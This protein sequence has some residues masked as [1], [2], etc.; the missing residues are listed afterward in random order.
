MVLGNAGRR[1]DDVAAADE[2]GQLIVIRGNHEVDPELGS[3][4][5]LRRSVGVIGSHDVHRPLLQRPHRGR[6][7]DRQPVDKRRLHGSTP[8]DTRVKSPMK[9]PRAAAT[10]TA[11][12]SQKRM[13]TVV[14]GHPTSS[15]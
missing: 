1:H 13:I 3:K 6:A 8:G 4:L 5:T 11:A 12:M 9:M 7:G 14:S 2:G 10:A 15:K